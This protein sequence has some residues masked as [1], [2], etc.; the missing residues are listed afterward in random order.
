MLNNPV[1]ILNEFAQKNKKLFP[2][3]NVVSQM[4]EPHNR[5]FCMNCVFMKFQTEGKYN[6][7]FLSLQNIRIGR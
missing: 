4:G 1:S 6:L 3:Y 2:V 7:I 5:K